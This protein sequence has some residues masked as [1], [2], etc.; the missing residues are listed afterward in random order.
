MLRC[1]LRSPQAA[2]RGPS[3]ARAIASS[4]APIDLAAEMKPHTLTGLGGLLQRLGQ[5]E[6]LGDKPAITCGVSGRSITYADLPGRIR[7]AAEALEATHSFGRGDTMALHLPNSPEYAVAF[8]GVAGAGGTNT[9]S[10]PLYTARELQGQLEDSGARLL[11]TSRMWAEVAEEAAAGAPSCE[12]VLYVEDEDCFVHAPPSVAGGQELPSPAAGGAFNLDEDLVVLPYSS[13]TTGKP[14]G[15]MLSHANLMANVLQLT[16][17]AEVN[18]GYDVDDVVLGVLPFFHIYGM[19]VIMATTFATG[20]SVVTL[21]KFDPEQ[22]LSTMAEHKV[23]VGMLV[24]PICI[25]LAKHPMVDDYD[26]SALRMIFSG[27]A[28]LDAATEAACASR[29]GGV[30]MRQGSGMTELSPVSHLNPRPG[31][32]APIKTGTI[33]K[34]VPNM[35]CKVVCTDTGAELG[36]HGVGE[37]WMKG[38]NR[39]VGYLNRPD[40]NAETITED[41][42]LKTG[43]IGHFD[44]DGYF[45]ISDRIKDLIKVKGFQVAPAEL[46]GLLLSHPAVADCAVIGVPDDMAGEVPKA[47]IALKP[48]IEEGDATVTDIKQFIADTVA[49]FKQ[50]AHI[51]FVETIPKSAAGKILKR[52]LRD[53]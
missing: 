37:L 23:T 6:A 48:G 10:N 12:R 13:G 33:G 14:K 52:M 45:T 41:G 18:I 49:E 24:P 50:I 21:P 36:P 4:V 5:W 1:F 53:Q 32:S 27:A 25:F 29:L 51:T 35:E 8:L 39:M 31:S 20:A 42:F 30:V 11:L 3:L 15:V 22:F 44:E 43:D 2:L 26:L 38:P 19:V 40:A 7:G 46:E 17:D 16:A 28:P 34:I 9:T 47:F